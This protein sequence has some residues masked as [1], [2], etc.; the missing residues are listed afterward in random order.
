MRS[1]A[2]SA[3]G[4]ALF[5]AAALPTCD[6]ARLGRPG[7][8]TD[9]PLV[10]GASDGAVAAVADATLDDR[11][12][13]RADGDQVDVATDAD[14][15]ADHQP[16]ADSGGADSGTG[17]GTGR[18]R[19]DQ[20]S[21]TLDKAAFRSPRTTWASA[22]ASAGGVIAAVNPDSDTVT[23]LD[24]ATL[25]GA[26]EIGVGDDP[27]TIA[28]TDDAHYA[29]VVNRAD[30]TV[31]VVDLRE[32]R[33][34]FY[35]AVGP[36]P[37]GVVLVGDRAYVTE[38]ARGDLAVLDLA[39]RTIPARIPIG[40]SP[41]GIGACLAPR[42]ALP[43]GD[44]L[45]VTH[46]Y[47]G[48]LTI[49]DRARLTITGTVSTGA[50]TNLSQLVALAPD[51]TRAYLPQTRF[52]A[53]N[54][55]RQFDTTVFPVV[56]VVQL[57]PAQ[58]VNAARITLDTADRPVAM[59][60]AV[61]LSNDGHTLWVANAASDDLS[62]VDLTTQLKTAH[63]E[64]GANPR[65]ILLSPDGRRAYVNETLD[66]TL[67]VIDTATFLITARATLTRLP[68]DA[69]TLTGKRIFHSA[70]RADLAK[71]QW[72]ACA[73][74]HFD[75]STDR[76]TWLSFPDGPRNTTALFNLEDTLPLH[77][78]GDLNEVADVEATVRFIQAGTGLSRVA[79]IDTLGPP[80][81]GSS[82]DLDA[83]SHFI[84]AIPAPR[85]PL[86]PDAATIARG[87]AAFNSLGCAACHAGPH[88][89]D[90]KSHDVG[91]GNAAVERNGH[92]RGTSFDTPSL[93]ALWLTPP[94]LHDGSATTLDEV[95]RRGNVHDVHAKISTPTRAD[96]TSFLLSL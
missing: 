63:I 2:L 20:F 41:A 45:L 8:A 74:C 54:P 72:M 18:V 95:F 44:S 96:L 10:V 39:T 29:V 58:L 59:P 83:L 36:M 7:D 37:Y 94:Y 75:G 62:V 77:W 43:S 69:Q 3:L 50:D 61:D 33:E 16:T 4:T 15:A 70:N 21:G 27:R 71:D 84:R 48:V 55:N 40:D 65:A 93:R 85:S 17:G 89:T 9:G 25:E 31:S 30:A 46:F 57:V 90:R 92:G 6:D 79:Q 24:E 35:F 82:A 19:A 28:I 81:A 60:F 34:L 11:D 68:L 67:A 12:L 87:Q 38:M 5:F 51:G 49:V 26:V 47:S 42:C 64:V 14:S 22:L 32:G 91:T 86:V 52:N 53:D 66:G 1:A 13:A 56:N 78:S 80:L 73:T 76:R 23:V 88:Y